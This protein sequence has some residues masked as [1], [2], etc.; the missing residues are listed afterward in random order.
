MKSSKLFITCREATMFSIKK[1]ERSLPFSER[2]KL[3]L[4]LIIC[5]FCRLF[6]RQHIF[7]SL[8]IKNLHTNETLTDIEKDHMHHLIE[9]AADQN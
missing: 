3:F 4:H 5:E 9:S 6:D 8:Q 2:I 1:E 7:L